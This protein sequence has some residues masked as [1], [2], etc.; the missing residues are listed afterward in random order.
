MCAQTPVFRGRVSPGR[1]L[2]LDV[3]F[4]FYVSDLPF[5]VADAEAVWGRL[6]ATEWS[7][8]GHWV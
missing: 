1:K 8:T 7:Q 2:Y 6:G 5:L 3:D 4:S